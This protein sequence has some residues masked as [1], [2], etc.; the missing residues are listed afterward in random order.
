MFLTCHHII[1][2]KY[3]GCNQF[4]PGEVDGYNCSGTVKGTCVNHVVCV[5]FCC[6]PDTTSTSDAMVFLQR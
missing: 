3:P 6:V 1:Y 5:Y 2:D 4:F